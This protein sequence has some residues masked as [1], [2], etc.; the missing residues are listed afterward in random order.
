MH[1]VQLLQPYAQP[2]CSD[3]AV[4]GTARQRDTA[5][6]NNNSSTAA[7]KENATSTNGDPTADETASATRS[8]NSGVADGANA[9]H[10]SARRAPDA[11]V[12]QPKPGT[13]SAE[14]SPDNN[15]KKLSKLEQIDLVRKQMKM[16]TTTEAKMDDLKR[17]S[18][19]RKKSGGGNAENSQKQ[20]AKKSAAS[21]AKSH[22]S[23]M[24]ASPN[25]LGACT[26]CTCYAC[27][28]SL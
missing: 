19:E 1:C 23:A 26:S 27:L 6:S 20:K 12:E 28:S 5:A 7:A 11:A 13:A 14:K 25:H 3:N 17:A 8:S 9:T 18:R 21:I 15:G 4:A 2:L 10:H 22:N 24:I 16:G